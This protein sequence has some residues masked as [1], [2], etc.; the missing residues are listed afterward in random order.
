MI[1]QMSQ[2]FIQTLCL[3]LIS[4]LFS[5]VVGFLIALIIWP[6]WN[7]LMPAIF[8]LPQI[9]YI[10]SWGLSVLLT[11]LFRLNTSVSY[12]QK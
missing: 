6:L 11:L 4:L 7:W 12:N 8:G 3:M 1:L 10:Q 9:T 5:I 2:N